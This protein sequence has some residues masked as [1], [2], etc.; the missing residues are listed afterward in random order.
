MRYSSVDISVPVVES[1]TDFDVTVKPPRHAEIRTL[2]A[3]VTPFRRIARF[4][5][6]RYAAQRNETTKTQLMTTRF[7]TTRARDLA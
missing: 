6:L 3:P 5:M 7:G 4:V 2:H 1:S